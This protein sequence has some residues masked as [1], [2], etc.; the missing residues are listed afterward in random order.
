M[1]YLLLFLGLLPCAAF[2]QY[3][4]DYGTADTT[5]FQ[6]LQRP[7]GYYFSTGHYGNIR[8]VP[9]G[10]GRFTLDRVKPVALLEFDNS[11]RLLLHQSGTF[12]WLKD[13]PSVS[14]S[15][16]YRQD[17][18]PSSQVSVRL[19]PGGLSIDGKQLAL[20]SGLVYRSGDDTYTFSR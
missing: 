3:A 2:A 20:V 8:M 12:T 10:P 17:I 5:L 14:L 9:A 18:D 4:G 11:G 6:I 15:G 7:D 13:T 16:G 1:K 19:S